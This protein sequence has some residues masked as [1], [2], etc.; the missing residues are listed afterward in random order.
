MV[1]RGR[2][3]KTSIGN[4]WR[5]NIENKN[6]EQV[7][8]YSQDARANVEILD[9]NYIKPNICSQRTTSPHLTRK[10]SALI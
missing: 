5:I 3:N 6:R 8:N 1:P 4:F 2:W 10:G 7:I 9:A